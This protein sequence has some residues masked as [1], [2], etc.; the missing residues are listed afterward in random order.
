MET[1]GFEPVTLC[2]QSI[3]STIELRPH[4][5]HYKVYVSLQKDTKEG[6]R[7]PTPHETRT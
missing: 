2:L 3:R 4:I 7:T 5:Y 1:T 6:T